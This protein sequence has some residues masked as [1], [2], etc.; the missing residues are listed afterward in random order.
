[1]SHHCMIVFMSLFFFLLKQLRI[2]L[3]FVLW[4]KLAWWHHKR[5][6]KKMLLQRN[7]IAGFFCRFW[8][9]RVARG[10]SINAGL[11]IPPSYDRWGN[12]F[13]NYNKVYSSRISAHLFFFFKVV[14]NCCLG[15]YVYWRR[16]GRSA[17]LSNRPNGSN[18]FE[19]LDTANWLVKLLTV[20]YH[21]E[22]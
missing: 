21:E 1:M 19:L 3:L 13:F 15:S 7:I 22:I 12:L 20:I 9:S 10:P 16:F 11:L 5:Y 18:I 6:Q 4:V 2:K 14:F 8:C 17:F